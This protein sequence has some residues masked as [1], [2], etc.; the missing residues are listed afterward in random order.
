MKSE[1]I[2]FLTSDWIASVI[3]KRN[4]RWCCL[5]GLVSVLTLRRCIAPMGQAWAYLRSFRRKHLYSLA[6]DILDLPSRAVISFPAGYP[7]EGFGG[8][9][10]QLTCPHD[11]EYCLQICYVIT[12]G[13]A[14]HCNIVYVVFHCSVYMLIED[15]IIALWYVALAFFNPKGIII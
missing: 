9:H 11:S 3:S 14:F 8:I 4:R 2:S 10:L 15:C 7:Q 13:T 1:S 5:T 6:R 12:F